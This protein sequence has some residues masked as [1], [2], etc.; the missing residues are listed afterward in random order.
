[1]AAGSTNG[2][3]HDLAGF[4]T[5]APFAPGAKLESGHGGGGIGRAGDAGGEQGRI[6]LPA[7][8]D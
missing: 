4:G 7:A 6:A 2:I 8:A 1:M 3:A 5:S